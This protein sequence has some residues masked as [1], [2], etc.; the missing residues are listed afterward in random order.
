MKVS[1]I[2]PTYNCAAHLRTTLNSIRLCGWDDL[3]IIIRD[4][5]STDGTMEQIADFPD[6]PIAALSEP[7]KGQ[8]DAINKGLGSASGEI[9]CWLNAGDLFIPGAV[10]SA[11]DAFTACPEMNW[12]TGLQCVAEGG[13]IRRVAE[14]FLLVSDFEIRL[15]LCKGKWAG[16]L[17][18]EGMFW[19]RALWEKA[20]PL[21][22]SYH[23]AG[24]FELWTRFARV[25][26]L[27]RANIPF[28]AFCY[29][30][31][32]RS[33]TGKN[34]YDD[35]VR[36]AIE[37]LP[38][39]IRRLHRLFVF[40][41]VTWRVLRRIPLIRDCLSLLFRLVPIFPIK[42]ISFERRGSLFNVVCKTRPSWVE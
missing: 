22:L 37:K 7:D 15:G 11:V 26:P 3:E 25:S 41:P 20:G 16:H 39:Q 8:Y 9:F 23:L 38:G 42:V 6:L 31:T 29:H 18:Q 19:R 4:G 17:Q 10:G 35:D 27:Y 12:V 13:K 30:G 34:K 24:D 28:A 5:A 33:I 36:V 2:I 21:D 40:L 1:I 32:N 14:T